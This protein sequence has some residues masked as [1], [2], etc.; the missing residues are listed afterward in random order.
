VSE[1]S[2][3]ATVGSPQGLNLVL[4][5]LAQ[6][7]DPKNGS[8]ALEVID[9]AADA[10]FNGVSLWT[11]LED[12][13]AAEGL[14]TEALIEH[15]ASRGLSIASTEALTDWATGDASGLEDANIHRLEMSVS[16]GAGHVIA[17]TTEKDV[18]FRMVTAGLTRLCDLASAH[19]LQVSF[20][21][22]PFCR[23][24]TLADAVRLLDA[25]DRDNLGLVIDAWHWF[26]QPGGPD[27]DG[28]RA[29]PAD[30]IHILQISDAPEASEPDLMLETI[31]ARLL[32]GE[33]VIDLLG[34]LETLAAM[35]ARPITMSE[36]FSTALRAHGSAEFARRQYD[37]MKAILERHWSSAPT[38]S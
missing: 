12:W 34:L 10:G 18:P 1:R 31:T 23:V 5:P 15:H 38:P 13:G 27:L 6:F 3:R 19:G 35:G 11:A 36:V 14:T 30:R 28:L 32:P 24:A 2:N 17:F 21:F 33:G 25:V 7:L 16:A 22:L 29:V 4:R 26:R 20:E 9:A 37:S 8:Q